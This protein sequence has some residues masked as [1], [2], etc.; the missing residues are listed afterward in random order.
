MKLTEITYTSQANDFVDYLSEETFKLLEG[1]SRNVSVQRDLA[2]R[3]ISSFLASVIIERLNELP[4]GEFT[5]RQQYDFTAAN[6]SEVKAD[7]QNAVATA[8]EEALSAF[9]GKPVQYYCQVKPVPEPLN[10]TNLPC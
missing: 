2:T 4:E 7:V 8:F 10:P 1:K 5:E 3:Y 6:F 9:A